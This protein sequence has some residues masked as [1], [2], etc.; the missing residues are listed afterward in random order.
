MKRAVAIVLLLLASGSFA[1]FVELT[2]E[3][4]IGYG[5]CAH[6]G[7]WYHCVMVLAGEDKLYM[8]AFDRK[9][10]VAIW[11]LSEK[12]PMLVWSREMI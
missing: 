10:E 12:E 11:E 7:K 9:G 8:V 2:Q 5:E 3:P 1:G 4:V 6:A